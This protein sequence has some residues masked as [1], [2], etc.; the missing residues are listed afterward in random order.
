MPFNRPEGGHL[1]GK[2]GAWGRGLLQH[3]RSPPNSAIGHVHRPFDDHAI[4]NHPAIGH[5]H[6]PFDVHATNNPRGCRPIDIQPTKAK[7]C[8]AVPRTSYPTTFT[9]RSTPCRRRQCHPASPHRCRPSIQTHMPETPGHEQDIKPPAR[10]GSRSQCC[11]PSLLPK[12]QHQL[13]LEDRHGSLL[14]RLRRDILQFGGEALPASASGG[15][16]WTAW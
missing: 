1:Q 13:R 16:S 14:V 9:E 5:V 3:G 8:G 6:R 12:A 2:L 11:S 15:T 7:H 4:Q 10:H